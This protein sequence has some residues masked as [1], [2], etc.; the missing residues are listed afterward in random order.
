[1]VHNLVLTKGHHLYFAFIVAM[2][3]ERVTHLSPALSVGKSWH[4]WSV[5]L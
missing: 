4:L 5:F 2:G 3:L 1:M